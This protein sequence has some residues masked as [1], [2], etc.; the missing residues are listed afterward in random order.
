MSSENTNI[1]IYTVL[2]I[3]FGGKHIVYTMGPV[4]CNLVIQLNILKT[5][6]HPDSLN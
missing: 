6:K 2:C 5:D 3:L 4:Q 1:R